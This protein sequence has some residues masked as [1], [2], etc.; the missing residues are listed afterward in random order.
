M[1]P[2][3]LAVVVPVHDEEQLLAACLRSVET[4]A[5]AARAAGAAVEV[6]VV[7]DACSDAS[8]SIASEFDVQVVPIDAHNV[9][10]A[11]RAGT[12]AALRGAPDWIAHTDADTV[13]P[14]NWLTHQ[15]DL[16]AD[17]ADVM[18]GNVRPDFSGLSHAHAAL[19]HATHPPGVANGNVH[20]ANLG[21][22]SSVY[23]A[24]GGFA[25]LAEHEDV[26]LVDAARAIGARVVATAACEV[27]TSGRFVGRTPGG[28]AAFLRGVDA[29]LS[30]PSAHPPPVHSV[31]A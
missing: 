21:I 29:E 30:T 23:R 12:H 18:L 19:W 17:G 22:R 15:L 11:R 14:S 4:A 9:G 10:A 6:F 28:Y 1:R 8:A 24:V 20:G 3:Q 2:A 13:V 26:A 5:A 31:R 27:V 7:L 25:P 16:L